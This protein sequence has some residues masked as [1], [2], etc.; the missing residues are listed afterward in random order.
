MSIG[1][2]RST[3]MRPSMISINSPTCPGGTSVGW[4]SSRSTWK[5]FPRISS[6]H[7][8]SMA[9]MMAVRAWLATSVVRYP[10]WTPRNPTV[11]NLITSSCPIPLTCRI[12]QNS[13][14]IGKIRSWRGCCSASPR[15]AGRGRRCRSMAK[16]STTSS[17]RSRAAT[18]RGV[19]HRWWASSVEIPAKVDEVLGTSQILTPWSFAGCFSSAPEMACPAIYMAEHLDAVMDAWLLR[20]IVANSRYRNRIGHAGVRQ[21]TQYLRLR[22]TSSLRGFW[23]STECRY[24]IVAAVHPRARRHCQR[25]S[26]TTWL[27]PQSNWTKNSLQMSISTNWHAVMY[28]TQRLL[29]CNMSAKISEPLE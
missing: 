12:A 16:S 10:R 19:G 1:A 3:S 9:P 27:L 13:H 7:S 20:T 2:N 14:H 11:H 8:V 5:L 29:T 23:R 28:I 25:N 26:D 24:I 6:I 15:V 22:I 17:S 18:A 21:L 4:G